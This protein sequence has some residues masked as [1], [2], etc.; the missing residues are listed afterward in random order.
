[1]INNSINYQLFVY[2]RLN[3][4]KHLFSIKTKLN[5]S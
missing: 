2:T 4:Q 1:M 5:S 3:N